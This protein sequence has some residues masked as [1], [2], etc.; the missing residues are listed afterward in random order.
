MSTLDETEK[1]LPFAPGGDRTADRRKRGSLKPM[2]RLYSNENFPLP[3]GEKLRQLGHDVLTIQE[4][5]KGGQR[6]EDEEVLEFA[7]ADDRILLT[8]N[9]KHFIS[10]APE[11]TESLRHYRLYL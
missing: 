4:T 1:L 9:R 3:V 11:T 7:C 10:P 5:G 2:A 6:I 8:L